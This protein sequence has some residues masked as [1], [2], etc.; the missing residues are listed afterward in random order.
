[1]SH[2]VK[3]NPEDYISRASLNRL[4][5]GEERDEE[6]IESDKE[7]DKES[8]QGD[9]AKSHRYSQAEIEENWYINFPP[10]DESE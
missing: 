6:S 8:V 4:R 10:R 2:E 3:N 7:Q 9:D 5:D 1:M